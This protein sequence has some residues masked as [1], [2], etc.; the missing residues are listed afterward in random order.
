MTTHDSNRTTR[1]TLFSTLYIIAIITLAV[2]ATG[3]DWVPRPSGAQSNNSQVCVSWDGDNVGW[4]E[5]SGVEVCV[6]KD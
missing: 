4:V 3:C 6:D 5:Y 2:V 1:Q